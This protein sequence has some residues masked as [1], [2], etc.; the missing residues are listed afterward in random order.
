MFYSFLSGNDKFYCWGMPMGISQSHARQLRAEPEVPFYQGEPVQPEDSILLL[1]GGYHV[2]L[3]DSI[4]LISFARDWHRWRAQRRG[5]MRV[6]VAES[7]QP[8][9]RAFL[10]AAIKVCLQNIPEKEFLTV[11]HKLPGLQFPLEPGGGIKSWALNRSMVSWLYQCCGMIFNGL[12]DWGEF[13]PPAILD[14]PKSFF[15]RLGTPNERFILFQGNSTSRT[16]TLSP[17]LRMKLIQHLLA[18]HGLP[19]Y[20]VD[21]EAHH[22]EVAK[23]S[24]VRTFFGKLSTLAVFALGARADLIVSPDTLGIHLGE[25]FRRPTVGILGPTPPQH[26]AW[27]Y[28]V[29]AFV[30]GSGFCQ[31]KPCGHTSFLPRKTKCPTRDLEF[32]AVTENIDLAVFDRA[33][34][35]TRENLARAHWTPPRPPLSLREEPAV[36]QPWAT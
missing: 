15:R 10:P 28:R 30:F 13:A 34:A 23:L 31:N 3:G 32:C 9:Y 35:R 25:A 26:M 20:I 36:M 11:T 19:V 24:G 29:P 21:T 22:H 27:G 1:T 2:A 7:S 33:V 17:A 6:G 16:R 18:Q 8:L 4:W 12:P 14:P 5:R